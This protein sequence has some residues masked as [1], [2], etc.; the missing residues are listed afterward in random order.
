MAIEYSLIQSAISAAAGLE[1]VWLGGRLTQ[2]REEAREHAREM[3]DATYL[4]ILVVTHLDRFANACLHVALDDGTEEGRPAGSNGCWAPTVTPPAFDPLSFDVNW[5]A[6]PANLMYDILSMPYRIEQLEQNLL[7][8]YE[9]DGPP[10]YAEYFWARQYGYAVL[11]LEFSEL[12]QQLRA[13]ADLPA[14]PEEPG[15]WNRDNQ[16]RGKRDKVEAERT[17]WQT[18]QAAEEQHA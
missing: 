6:L 4:A 15:D 14:L 17:A 18:R 11:G 13:H 9:Y 12:A 8:V 1:G 10:D 3:K 5:K 16:L 7:N 2:K